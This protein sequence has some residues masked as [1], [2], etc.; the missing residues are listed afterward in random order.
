MAVQKDQILHPIQTEILLLF[1]ALMTY[2][3]EKH[4]MKI[5]IDQ[6]KR[7]LKQIILRERV[8]SSKSGWQGSSKR[9]WA[10]GGEQK[11]F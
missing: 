2:Y 1:N 9:K 3:K 6:G 4:E 7:K 5:E 10:I 11:I 8:A